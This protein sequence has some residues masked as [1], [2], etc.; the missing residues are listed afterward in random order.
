MHLKSQQ[1]LQQLP[2][3]WIL[4][5]DGGHAI[6]YRYHKNKGLMAMHEP[7]WHSA[8]KDIKHHE[9]TVVPDMALK[10]ESL[11][12]FQVSHDDS[13]SMV[14]GSNS[15][16]NNVEPHL[17]IHDEVKQNLVMAIAAKLQQ[18]NMD[19]KFDRLVIAAPAKIL[20]LLR[21]HLDAEVMARVIAEVPKD[22]THDARE[23][24]LAHLQET[25][26]EAHVA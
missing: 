6:V 17:D 1:I 12:D 21:K 5:A 22:Y 10:A 13:G 16:H 18:A 11:N 8:N 23:A 24:L 19:K 7:Q 26:T 15:A 2:V 9:L 25:L 4:V 14:G 20:G 3:I